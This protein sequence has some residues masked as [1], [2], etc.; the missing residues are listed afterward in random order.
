MGKEWKAERWVIIVCV[1]LA[2]CAVI[3]RL[4]EYR[5]DETE[6]YHEYRPH[7]MVD[8]V[9]YWESRE[10]LPFEAALPVG[11]A[12]FS[13]VESTTNGLAEKNGQ[14][15]GLA[16]GAALCRSEARPGIIYGEDQNGRWKRL[17]VE[18]LR[19]DLLRYDGKVYISARASIP[20]QE[21]DISYRFIAKEYAPTGE[22]VSFGA[23]EC[24]PMEDGMVNAR[25]YW[26]FHVYLNPE[27]ED[28]VALVEERVKDGK[29]NH[30]YYPFIDAESIGLD[31]SPYEWK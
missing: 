26:G 5:Q 12:P 20:T 7:L 8:D 31:Y 1:V 9:I 30:Q 13:E 11:F 10:A 15:N 2:V 27:Q 16:V 4:A 29:P 21:L 19:Q 14:A 25:Y 17:V 3:P 24:V 6:V 22:K 18:E 23:G 28:M